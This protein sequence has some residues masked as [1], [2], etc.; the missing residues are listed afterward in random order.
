MRRA[1]IVMNGG[2]TAQRQRRAHRHLIARYKVGPRA[3]MN[4][5]APDNKAAPARDRMPRGRR[6]QTESRVSDPWLCAPG[7][8]GE[9]QPLTLRYTA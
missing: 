5:R 9:D 4:L 1:K 2:P 8:A 3:A 7:V 6:A